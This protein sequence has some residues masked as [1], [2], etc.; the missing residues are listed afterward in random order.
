VRVGT[1]KCLPDKRD[2][3]K[4]RMLFGAIVL[5]L[6]LVVAPASAADAHVVSC[7]T[8]VQKPVKLSG[9]VIRGYA[10]T[11][12]PTVAK[13]PL[14]YNK[15][16]VQARR[17]VSY[18]EVRRSK[19]TDPFMDSRTLVHEGWTSTFRTSGPQRPNIKCSKG[20]QYR[21]VAVHSVFAGDVWKVGQFTYHGAP[22]RGDHYKRSKW[23]TC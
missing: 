17:L 15:D 12:C 7:K 10:F 9:S 5:T 4:A 11:R 14:F 23:I 19:K 3:M 1:R 22:K 6:G 21:T 8:K 20:L 2:K 16:H 18:L 13:E